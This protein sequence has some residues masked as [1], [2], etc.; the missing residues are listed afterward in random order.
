[1]SDDDGPTALNLFA[2]DVTVS[3]SRATPGELLD[4]P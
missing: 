1:V 4:R 2:D 3:Y